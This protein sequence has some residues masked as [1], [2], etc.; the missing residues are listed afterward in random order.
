MSSGTRQVRDSRKLYFQTPAFWECFLSNG[1]RGNRVCGAILTAMAF[2]A[3]G[4]SSAQDFRASEGQWH[5]SITPYVWL[6]S[7]NG[8]LKYHL[9]P[10]EGGGTEIQIGP[11]GYLRNLQFAALIAGEIG[12]GEYALVTDVIY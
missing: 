6:P 4:A 1:L 8:S 12:K 3:S 10:G 2:W 9:P 7:V 5:Y 11:N